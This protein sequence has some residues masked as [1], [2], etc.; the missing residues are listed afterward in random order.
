MP[1]Q[2]I[3]KY[4]GDNTTFIWKHPV[5]DFNTGSILI[6][7]E[8]QEAIFFYDGK[9]ANIFGPGRY[10]LE[11]ENLP[12]LRILI[13]IPT[14]GESR[15]HC[16][17]YFIN[18]VEQMAIAW[19]TDT[20]IQYIDPTYGIPLAIGAGGEMSLS[21]DDSKTLLLRLVGTE[22]YLGREKLTSFFRGIMSTK[23]KTFLA[24]I[25]QEKGTSIFEVDQY[26]DDYSK[27]IKTELMPVFKEYGLLLN[28]FT[29]TR[30][31][32]PDGDRQYEL[33]KDI[34]FRK[35]SDIAEAK[36]RQQV[37]IIEQRTEAERTVIEAQARAQKRNIEGYTYQ[38]ERGFDVA[39]KVAQNE[40]AGNLSSAGV[41]LGVMAGVGGTIGQMTGKVL[42]ESLPLN[43]REVTQV[44]YCDK[45]GAQVSLGADFCDQCGNPLRG[46]EKCNNCGY[47]FERPGKYCPKCGIKRD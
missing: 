9:V 15:F 16:E 23:V 43:E 39:E 38:Q 28:Y 21:V 7:H 44:K 5:E 13:N 36:I 18:K 2:Q 10:D 1:I 25:M 26:L 24:Q 47:V 14:G 45:C 29:I 6:V 40:G 31:V 20:K 17:V 33:F 3:I 12:F 34:H 35:Y 27:T 46:G 19:G 37:G 8:A 32:K 11:T 22:K 42:K 4:E 41:G 30:F